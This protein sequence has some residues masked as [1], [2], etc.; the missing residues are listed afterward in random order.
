MLAVLAVSMLLAA[1][2]SSDSDEATVTVYSGRTE[3][4]IGPI[5]E[6]FAAETGINVAVNYGE[7][8]DLALLITEEGEQTRADVFL[9]QSPGAV[10]FLDRQG[11]LSILPDE[12]LEL[13]P[14]TV[15]DDAGHWIGFSGRQRVLVY[16]QELVDPA[17]LPNSVFDLTGDRW[18][19]Q[20]GVAPSNGSFQDF[21]TSMRGLVGDD[22]TLAWL[23]GLS[24]ND[25]QTYPNNNAIVAAV[26][27]GEIEVGLVNHYYNYRFLAEDPSHP[28]VNHQFA[29]DDPGS[30]LIVTGAALVA[31]SENTEAAEQLITWLLGE[32]AQRFFADETFEYP[33]VPGIEPAAGVPS[34][35]FSAVGGIDFGDLGDGLEGTRSLITDAGLDG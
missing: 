6:E 24:D 16:N 13:V 14:T 5:L 12:I 20:L 27:R 2:C 17:E 35:E 30:L 25:V 23:G 1:S 33:L 31:G 22:D 19:G 18:R 34:A 26:G 3:N 8:S 4:L 11:L 9:S 32:S 15:Q 21:V 28:G 7:S 10:E 29:I